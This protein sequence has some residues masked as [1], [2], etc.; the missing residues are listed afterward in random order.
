M[1]SSL[2]SLPLLAA[3]ALGLALKALGLP[4]LVGFLLAGFALHALG[5]EGGGLLDPVAH[6]GV[7]LLLFTV[8]LKLRPK[9]LV[10]AEVW[11]AGLVHLLVSVALGVAALVVASGLAYRPAWLVAVAL[12]FS[13]TVLAAKMLGERRELRAFHG[14]V[15][16]GI[17]VVQDLVAV[18][19]LALVGSRTTSPWTLLVIG[20]PLARPVLHALLDRVGHDELL[21][22]LG[23]T[24]TLV[25]GGEAFEAVGLSG[26]LGALLLGALVAGHPRAGELS[27]SLWGLKEAFLVAFFLG[28]GIDCGPPDLATLSGAAL[29]A[30]LLPLKAV[31][32]FFLLLLFRLRAR[33][34]FLASLALASYSE[35]ALIVAQ[36]AAHNGWLD[37]AWLQLIAVAVATSFA[38]AAPLNHA[39]HA[40]YARFEAGLCRLE[41]ER[42]HPDEQPLSLGAATVV[43]VGMGRIGSGAYDLLKERGEKVV[44]LDSDPGKVEHNLRS[45]RRVVYGDGEDPAL[46]QELR[47][48]DVRAVLL[49]LPDAEAKRSAA[50]ELRRR[51]YPG[52]IA[53]T[54]VYPEEEAAL[55]AA[56]ADLTFNYYGEAGATFA[57]RAC[58]ALRPSEAVRP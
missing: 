4:P 35:F 46:W 5:L 50:A 27:G 22:L 42:R 10:Q 30:L 28:I 40:L 6:A 31:L 2:E 57:E 21:V 53:A 37:P 34:A 43:V 33:T 7:L 56:G 17:L 39:A 51:G 54:G 45:G 15:A 23:L 36:V 13:S 14:R 12:A 8:G 24:L 25:A 16:I 3:F 29:L 47:L 38:I 19:V 1:I 44:G 18:T 48:G 52:L 55:R 58:E 11:G 9:S 20:L 41:S 32:F 26:E 49:A